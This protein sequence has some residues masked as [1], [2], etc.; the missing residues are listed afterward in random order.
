MYTHNAIL[1]AE[2]ESFCGDRCGK[3]AIHCN[4]PQ[5]SPARSLKLLQLFNSLPLEGVPASHWPQAENRERGH[6]DAR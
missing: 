2:P 1:R 3:P 4:R 6:E 5:G